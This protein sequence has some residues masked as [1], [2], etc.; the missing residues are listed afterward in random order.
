MKG[1]V[2][3]LGGVEENDVSSSMNSMCK[4]S[5]VW[6]CFIKTMGTLRNERK[7]AVLKHYF[8]T[9]ENTSTEGILVGILAPREF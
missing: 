4:G 5:V 2:W 1:K 8:K 9:N 7:T 6:F 3:R